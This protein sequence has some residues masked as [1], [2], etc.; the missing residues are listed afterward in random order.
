MTTTE[1]WVP[2]ARPTI[3]P[4]TVVGTLLIA[5]GL[6]PSA[7]VLLASR[8]TSVVE[9]DLW[10]AVIGAALSGAGCAL[11]ARSVLAPLSRPRWIRLGPSFAIYYTLVFG[12]L[13]LGWLTPQRGSAAIV[14]PGQVPPATALTSFA[15]VA[16]TIGYVLGGPRILRRG[17][18]SGARW[19]FPDGTWALRFPSMPILICLIGIAARL[20]RFSA[21]QWAYL[22][23]PRAALASTS[24]LN[25]FLA[26][27]EGC[28]AIGLVL[29]ALDALA[30]TRSTRSRVTLVVVFAIEVGAGIFGA[31][32]E[33]V[34]LSVASV[35]I[36]AVFAG[37]RLSRGAVV[38]M[39][40]LIL[41]VFPLTEAYRDSLRGGPQVAAIGAQ[42]AGG[43]L[44]GAVTETFA[45]LT[46]RALFI[47]SPAEISSRLR[48]IDNV[49]LIRQKT[50]EVIPYRPW[51]E[52]VYAP[53]TGLV[54]RS[55]WSGKPVLST[56]KAFS[57]QYYELP[58]T[59]YT[60]SAVTV[61]GDLLRHGGLVPLFLGMLIFGALLRVA[62]VALDPARD[63][64][65]LIL[66]VP[67][68]SLV[69]KLESDIVVL[70]VGALQTVVLAG[71]VGRLG[72][73]R[74][75]R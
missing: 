72:F 12:V 42:E 16:W 30:L 63:L 24:S 49:A 33:A 68:F 59:L 62:D 73:V 56:G 5:F 45:G 65:R 39:V 7:F 36:V 67:L 20:L 17:A 58:D 40:L 26:L 37:I 54:P 19:L 75:A 41:V 74:L 8:S 61:P 18:A 57:E 27:F 44:L 34:I 23:D 69:L 13:S 25:Q 52:L 70:I 43:S 48:E 47:D 10:I 4:G 71:V 22:Q 35:A 15:L 55:L 50:P 51:G 11:A 66:F 1:T 64:R 6:A 46:P 29:V 2:S 53:V 14:Q 28:A 9:R 60:A 31:S 21:G 38:G 3:R 32:K